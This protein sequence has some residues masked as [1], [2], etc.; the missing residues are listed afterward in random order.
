MERY[1]PLI[2]FLKEKIP[3]STIDKIESYRFGEKPHR[4]YIEAVKFDL[5][6]HD[7][8]LWF[9]LFHKK[10]PWTINVGYGKKKREI[11][12]FLRNSKIIKLDLL[13]KIVEF[14]D[15]ILDF[16]Q[17]S[18][19]NPILEMINDL[20]YFGYKMNESWYKELEIIEQTTGNVIRL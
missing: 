4:S 9:H 19:S 2:K 3:L 13:N 12:V 5:G 1:N 18:I 16:S 10:I 15:K 11:L 7:V 6:I 14:D 17:S 8:D 20:K